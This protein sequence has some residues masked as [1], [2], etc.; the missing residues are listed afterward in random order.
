MIGLGLFPEQAKKLNGSRTAGW[1]ED[2]IDAWIEGRRPGKTW[3]SQPPSESGKTV[4]SV[5]D[6]S[7]HAVD[8]Q[9]TQA[10]TM[11]ESSL[12][13]TGLVVF[14]RVVYLYQPTN[15]MLLDIGKLDSLSEFGFLLEGR[16][17]QKTK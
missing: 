6:Q 13:P 10:P 16:A 12:V 15:Q 14:G 17:A 4:R 2:D 7:I 1:F 8:R 5:P 3:A 11:Q 9:K